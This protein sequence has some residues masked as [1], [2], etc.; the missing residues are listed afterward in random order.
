M[1]IENRV[2]GCICLFV[3]V[4]YRE[5]VAINSNGNDLAH[6]EWEITVFD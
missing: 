6:F 5:F 1:G 3:L 2:D 4:F